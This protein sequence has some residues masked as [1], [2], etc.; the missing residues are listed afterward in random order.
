MIKCICPY[1]DV[2]LSSS[3]HFNY[4]RCYTLKPLSQTKGAWKDYGYSILLKHDTLAS[5][6]NVLPGWHLFIHEPS[7]PFSGTTYST[8]IGLL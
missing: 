5:T 4:G 1:A 3:L 2:E 7:E 8:R 6:S